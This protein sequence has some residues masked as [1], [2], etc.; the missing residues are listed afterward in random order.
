MVDVRPKDSCPCFDS[1]KKRSTEEL[2]ELYKKALNN[3]ITA[4]ENYKEQDCPELLIELKRELGK[5]QKFSLS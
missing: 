3:Q 2:I 4:L 5:A 1:L